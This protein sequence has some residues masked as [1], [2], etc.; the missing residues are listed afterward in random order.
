MQLKFEA[1]VFL[2]EEPW[3]RH[4][5]AP[6]LRPVGQER[7]FVFFS[8]SDAAASAAPALAPTTQP[9]HG[10]TPR[11]P[12]GFCSKW[13]FH[14]LCQLCAR[15]KDGRQNGGWALTPVALSPLGEPGKQTMD[16]T[17]S[18]ASTRAGMGPTHQ[19]AT[20]EQVLPS[21]R[22]IPRNG[23]RQR[24]ELKEFIRRMKAE[25]LNYTYKDRG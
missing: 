11:S 1:S 25:E 15:P 7:Q 17:E 8:S 20:E 6:G 10:S 21:A 9:S 5:E 24:L 14:A 18:V 22:S 16:D 4:H 19:G 2:P 23:K 12:A 13:G 3:E